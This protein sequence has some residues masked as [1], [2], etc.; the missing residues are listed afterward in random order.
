MRMRLRA[1]LCSLALLLAPFA[2]A[3]QVPPDEHWMTLRTQHFY[4]HYPRG[5]DDLGQRA[6][7]RAERAFAELSTDLVRPPRGRIDLVV[8]DNVDFSNGY[9]TPLPTNRV[10]IYA[11][12]PID[13]P[14]LSFYDDWLQLV[15]S[16]ELTH[17]FHL[18]HA[19]GVYRGLRSVLGRNPITFPNLFTPGWTKEGLAVF[20]ESRLTR[21]GRLRGSLHEMEIRTA[22][23]ED[24]FFSIDRASG[25]PASWPGGYTSYAYGS[26]FVQYLGTR[27]GAERVREFVRVVGRRAIPYNLDAAGTAAFGFPLSQLWSEWHAGLRTRY[28]ALADSLR[29]QGATEPEVLTRAGQQA[30][31]PRFLADGSIVYAANTGRAESATRIVTPGG[32]DRKLAPRTTLAPVAPTDG[33]G[34]VTSQIEAAD[35]YRDFSDLYRISPDGAVHRLTRGARLEEPDV[36]RAGR[37]VALR[38]GGGTTV[39]V[40]VDGATGAVKPLARPVPDVQWGLPRWSP[41]GSLIALSRWRRGGFL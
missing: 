8:S 21:A 1:V 40:L 12:P 13:E 20:E 14:A 17:T 3:A 7:A 11:H 5:L 34:F 27:L 37:I 39:P 38:T 30:E 19:T 31:F 24:R 9:S 36:S 26:E 23:L 25:N 28:A 22:V 41:D 6:A 16:H 15:I 10:V 2:A 35:P 29:R 32:A 4:V 33:G 18:D